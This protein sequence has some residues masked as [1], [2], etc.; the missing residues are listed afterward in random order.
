MELLD[1]YL[2]DAAQKFPEKKAII[3]DEHVIS[4]IELINRISTFSEKL[5]DSGFDLGKRAVILV[6]DKVDYLT[7]CFATMQAGG[8]AVPL[9]ETTTTHFIQKVMKDCD[10][11]LFITSKKETL[12]DSLSNIDHNCTIMYV[13]DTTMPLFQSKRYTVPLLADNQRGALIL[14]THGTN[15]EQKS[16]LMSHRNLIHAALSANTIS[17]IDSSIREFVTPQLTQSFGFGRCLSILINGGTIVVTNQTITSLTITETI[18]KH[19]CNAL[20]IAPSMFST[21]MNSS[22]SPLKNISSQLQVIDLGSKEISVQRKRDFLRMFPKARIF[23]HYGLTEASYCTSLELR[24]EEKKIQTVGRASPSVEI[25]VIDDHGNL[26]RHNMTGE[27]TVRGENVMSRYWH[28]SELTQQSFT[29]G[30]WLKTGDCGFLDDDGYLH[31]LGRKAEMINLG[32]TMFSPLEVEEKIREIFPDYEFC[33][34]GV[35]DPSGVR[36]EIPVLCYIP[37]EGKTINASELS[38]ALSNKVDTNKIPRIVYRIDHL[39]ISDHQSLRQEI[40]KHL[41]V[42]FAQTVNLL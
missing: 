13:D 19:R 16:V 7:A 26:L 10:P 11:L 1:Q 23:T 21:I 41:L 17:G 9:T 38:Q 24:S 31:V 27:I 35:P 5:R 15:G 29:E 6:H 33:V 20:S 34:I 14:H 8:I 37:H 3:C 40:R 39:S 4:Y 25:G 32:D 2:L 42:S 12:E 28:D 22:K 30:K 18:F 36:K